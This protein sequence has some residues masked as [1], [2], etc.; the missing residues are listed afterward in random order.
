MSAEE[1]TSF[2][3]ALDALADI[4]RELKK[5]IGKEGGNLNQLMLTKVAVVEATLHQVGSVP[6][7]S[8]MLNVIKQQ[9]ELATY[10]I[11]NVS[12]A[13][14]MLEAGKIDPPGDTNNNDID[15]NDTKGA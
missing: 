5:R 14:P 11:R 6:S 8:N 3:Q 2:Q 13:L 15:E 1:A 12:R 7:V 9:T 4:R 10:T